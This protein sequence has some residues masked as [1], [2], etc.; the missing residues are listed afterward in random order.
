MKVPQ[1]YFLIGI[2]AIIIFIIVLHQM[3]KKTTL[4]VVEQKEHAYN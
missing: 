1:K 3:S 2:G 4:S